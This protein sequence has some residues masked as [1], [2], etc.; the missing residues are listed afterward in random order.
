MTLTLMNERTELGTIPAFELTTARYVISGLPD[1]A[2]PSVVATLRHGNVLKN[3]M[4][5]TP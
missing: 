5:P 3:V 2:Q 4:Q 1:T